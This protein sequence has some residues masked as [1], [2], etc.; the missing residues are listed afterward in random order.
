MK[1][2]RTLH[3]LLALAFLVPSVSH[4]A[5]HTIYPT[6]DAYVVSTSPDS[7][8]GS[9]SWSFLETS[10]SDTSN[11]LAYLRF[12]LPSIPAGESL[13]GASLRMY[14][15]NGS[16]TGNGTL[17]HYVIDDSWNESTMTYNN[18]PAY[19]T[20]VGTNAN[21]GAYRGWSEWV[22]L[23]EPAMLADGTLSLLVREAATSGIQAHSFNGKDYSPFDIN[24][25][26]RRPYLSITT[27]PVPIPGALWLLGS[28]LLGLAAITRT[29]TR[30]RTK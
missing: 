3:A 2:I 10:R 20:Q 8:Y 28:G 17:A 22:L 1:S 12:D 18:R 11:R 7:N 21:D 4:A 6:A 9:S 14:Q 13:V 16:G 27:A 24:G 19:S 15:F 30:R 23:L 25:L 5:I 26:A 29:I